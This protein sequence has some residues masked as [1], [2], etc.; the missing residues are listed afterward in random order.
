MDHVIF[1]RVAW[2]FG[3][4]SEHEIFFYGLEAVQYIFFFMLLP[5]FSF[6]FF[7]LMCMH[8]FSLLLLCRN[9]FGM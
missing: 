5:T 9:F 6:L 3:S 8:K 4:F 7:G 2:K 1:S